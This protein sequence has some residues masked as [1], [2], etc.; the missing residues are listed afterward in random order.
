MIYSIYTWREFLSTLP[1]CWPSCSAHRSTNFSLNHECLQLILCVGKSLQKLWKESCFPNL[2]LGIL[3]ACIGRLYQPYWLILPMLPSPKH[4]HQNI[5][6]VSLVNM[7]N[8]CPSGRKSSFLPIGAVCAAVTTRVA[9][10]HSV[11]KGT[12]VHLKHKSPSL[13]IH[14]CVQH[15]HK[16]CRAGPCQT[17][18]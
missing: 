5:G 10:T 11:N 9:Q 17:S 13:C 16:T 1:T 12:G 2:I 7:A 15:K 14:G 8:M 4:P 3:Q 18:V 6:K